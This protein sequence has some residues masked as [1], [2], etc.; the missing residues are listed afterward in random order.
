[1]TSS[2]KSNLTLTCFTIR[3]TLNTSSIK[4]YCSI[5]T[6]TKALILINKSW[7][8][9]TNSIN[10][11][12]SRWAEFQ[13]CNSSPYCSL[14]TKYTFIILAFYAISSTWII[15]LLSWVKSKI[16]TKLTLS[17]TTTNFTISITWLTNS[18]RHISIISIRTIFYTSSTQTIKTSFAR[19]TIKY[20]SCTTFT[21]RITIS[22]K[23]LNLE[24]S[25]WT[26]YYT[27]S[28]IN[29]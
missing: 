27:T 11:L 23:I 25:C 28:L 18:L 26:T 16:I 29:K 19:S 12:W 9:N 20:S 5:W 17:W 15:T 2:T 13:T 7:I 22:T 8:T 14:S 4:R 6:H 10:W 1:M 3:I 24:S 21:C